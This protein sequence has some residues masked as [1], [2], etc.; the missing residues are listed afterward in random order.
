MDDFTKREKGNTIQFSDEAISSLIEIAKLQRGNIAIHT[1][2]ERHEVSAEDTPY[3]VAFL[4][5]YCA[6][7]QI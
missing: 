7:T 1:I 3:I 4:A 5:G 6:A 2:I